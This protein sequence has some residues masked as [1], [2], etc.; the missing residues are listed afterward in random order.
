MQLKTRHKGMWTRVHTFVPQQPTHLPSTQYVL[1]GTTVCASEP[2]VLQLECGML[3][4][5]LPLHGAQKLG[6]H[7]HKCTGPRHHNDPQPSKLPSTSAQTV[8][9]TGRKQLAEAEHCDPPKKLPKKRRN[10]TMSN[11]WHRCA[12]DA[13][14]IVVR[15]NPSCRS[16]LGDA[17]AV[18]TSLSAEK[19]PNRN[20]ECWQCT[21]HTSQPWSVVAHDS[22]RHA[23]M[24]RHIVMQG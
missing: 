15:Q 3:L 14:S 22:A 18:G 9:Q 17:A 20:L 21:P 24:P 19:N 13:A 8:L 10:T 16:P 23:R 12:A 5:I 7:A 2:L 4:V 1:T 6:R 11:T